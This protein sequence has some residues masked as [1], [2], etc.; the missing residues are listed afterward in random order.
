MK[1]AIVIIL[2]LYSCSDEKAIEK[3]ISQQ[4]NT[5]KRKMTL[6]VKIK[7]ET[8]NGYTIAWYDTLGKQQNLSNSDRP[9]HIVCAIMDGQDTLGYYNGLVNPST[10]TSFGAKDTMVSV[11]FSIARNQ[12]SQLPIEEQKKY[13]DISC[14]FLPVQLSV[15]SNL[16]EKIDILLTEK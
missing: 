4:K 12:F 11:Y 16:E 8:E 1:Y 7:K 2:F 15:K 13:P 6:T 9:F 3:Y 5:V 14:D 10:W